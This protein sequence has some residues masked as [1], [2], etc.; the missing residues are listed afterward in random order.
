[1]AIKLKKDGI[2]QTNFLTRREEKTGNVK[3]VI[4]PNKFQVG[5]AT[6]TSFHPGMC[7]YGQSIFYQGISGSLTKLSDGTSYLV[8]GS[9]VTIV[10]G[11]NGSITISSTGGS[12]S[13]GGSD[14]EV[15]FNDA[16]VFGGDSDFT[17]NK[18]TNTLTVTGTINA[19]TGLSGSLTKLTD[20]TSYLIAGSNVTVTTGTNGS[21]TIS[22]TGGG[23]T[24]GGSNTD[25]QFNDG[26]SFGGD[27]DFTYDKT[28]NELTLSGRT[29][30]K[31]NIE[32][33]N[34]LFLFN[35]L[36]R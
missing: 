22:S 31:W 4:S 2:L 18:T 15:Q 28:L 7:V 11:T 19:T 34:R 30:V 3:T 27:S 26:G 29:N 12:G 36:C 23:G 20:G 17:Y 14:T 1:M 13:P 16:G 10:T 6:D 5:L 24:P 32:T 25:V 35:K 9:N 8:A 33:I 21:V